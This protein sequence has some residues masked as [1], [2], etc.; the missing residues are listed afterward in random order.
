[1]F[2]SQRP[3]Q[4]F[5]AN[6]QPPPAG[7]KWGHDLYAVSQAGFFGAPTATASRTTMPATNKL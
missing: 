6:A 3:S 2:A 5:R 7:H 1:M 4:Q